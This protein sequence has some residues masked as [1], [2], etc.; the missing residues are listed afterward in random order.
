MKMS[1]SESINNGYLSLDRRSSGLTRK[2]QL[3]RLWF[4]RRTFDER[5][6]LY[7][8]VFLR[9][10]SSFFFTW[11]ENSCAIRELLCSKTLFLKYLIG[12]LSVF[13]TALRNAAA[14]SCLIQDQGI[15][16]QYYLERKKHPAATWLPKTNMKNKPNKAATVPMKLTLLWL[17]EMV[18][19]TCYSRS[20]LPV[21]ES[22]LIN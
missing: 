4:R 9:A 21:K 5:N 11:K 13:N 14:F 10:V 8:L 19:I 20:I 15:L 22:I 17:N 6:L 1:A 3:W 18:I 16:S 2:F 12:G 7:K